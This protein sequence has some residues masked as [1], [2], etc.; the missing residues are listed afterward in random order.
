MLWVA[1]ERETEKQSEMTASLRWVAR[2]R[3]AIYNGIFLTFFVVHCLFRAN[4]SAEVCHGT[5]LR[6][7][8]RETNE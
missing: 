4:Q 2:Y 7:V 6:H 1:E 8:E 5:P 3:Q